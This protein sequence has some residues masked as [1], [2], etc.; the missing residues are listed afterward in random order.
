[1]K[2]NIKSFTLFI[3]DDENSKKIADTIRKFNN[4]SEKPIVETDNGDLIIAIGGD[5]TF[6][7]AV[8]STGFKKSKIYAGIHTGTLGFLQN[9]SPNEIYTL[10]KYLSYEKEIRT[11]KVF[12]SSINI[13]LNTGETLTYFSLNEILV[14]GYNYSKI[15]FS[16]Y[17]NDELLQKVSGNGIVIAT[18]T[19]ETA[20]SLNSGGAIDFTNQHHLVCT[21]ETPI[22]NAAY[23]RFISNPVICNKISVVLETSDNI[24]INI[25]GIT[26]DIDSRQIKSVD[27]VLD[28]S[29]YINK[30]ELE[31][32]SKVNATREK[33]LGCNLFN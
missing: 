11:R 30:F 31:K 15:S 27:V 19:G 7:N 18:S 4:Y 26:R 8:T 10:I 23:E 28:G 3:R 1:M 13:N 2:N 17:I 6:L 25:D 22:L 14:V 24:S 5:G 16:E 33:I 12:I 20:Y 21:L 29:N 9:L 32:Y